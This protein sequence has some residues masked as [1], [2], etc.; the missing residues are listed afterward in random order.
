LVLVITEGGKRP[1]HRKVQGRN[2]HGQ[3]S[4][5]T[6]VLETSFSL[7]GF[8]RIGKSWKFL[9]TKG[10]KVQVYDPY[11]PCEHLQSVLGLKM[12]LHH[13]D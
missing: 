9:H 8:V 12:I 10:Q 5:A 6:V 3:S 13:F 7:A 4:S 1:G 2:N 11:D